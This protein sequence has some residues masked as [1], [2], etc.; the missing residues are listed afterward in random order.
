MITRI[1]GNNAALYQKLFTKAEQAIDKDSLWHDDDTAHTI[2]SLEQYFHYIVELSKIDK[3]YTVLPI[4]EEIFDIDANTRVITVPKSFKT[5]GIAVKGDHVAEVL[6]FRIDR[7]FDS[8]DLNNMEIFIQWEA[9]NGD[10]GLS[11]E[12]VRDIESNEGKL[13]FGWPIS[14]NIT[15]VA[16]PVK[17][18]VRFY[19]F[20]DRN[21]PTADTMLYNFSTLTATANV[22]PSLDLDLLN[23]HIE[24]MEDLILNRLVNSPLGGY[25]EADMP[26]WIY[27]LSDLYPDLIA[28]VNDPL[29]VQAFSPDAGRITYSWYFYNPEEKDEKGEQVIHYLGVGKLDYLPTEDTEYN[30]KKLYWVK[31][32]NDTWV[33]YQHDEFDTLPWEDV[34]KNLYE[35]YSLLTVPEKEGG[36]NG[37]YY[38]IAH[39]KVW[40]STTNADSEKVEVLGPSIIV[41]AND[42]PEYFMLEEGKENNIVLGVEEVEPKYGTT[43]YKWFKEAIPGVSEGTIQE[44]N[45][46]EVEGANAATLNIA[47]ASSADEG[48]YHVLI[49]RENNGAV[50]TE[51]SGYCDLLLPVKPFQGPYDILVT[52]DD[53]ED[54]IPSPGQTVTVRVMVQD[55]NYI[56]KIWWTDQNKQI[57]EGETGYSL[58]IP[59]TGYS[60]EYRFNIERTKGN[61]KESR[62]VLVEVK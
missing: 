33:L 48:R 13:I 24:K 14:N 52:T 38:A 62:S 50:I 46:V 16:G 32:Q 26:I 18:S 8:T 12:Y 9:P 29:R 10:T 56:D 20:V 19:D 58:N 55:T 53:P 35:E 3:K 47:N 49:T 2:Q 40:S 21:N 4:D 7:Y 15:E 17:F 23:T 41:I 34:V 30:P 44:E 1:T 45:P 43:T 54:A 22:N 59:T 36:S 28:R 11:R 60:H 25:V 31:G 27:N 39:N 57:I 51:E 37:I 5:N 6:Y 61:S 42:L